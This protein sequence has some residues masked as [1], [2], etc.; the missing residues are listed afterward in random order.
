MQILSEE[1]LAEMTPDE[2]REYAKDVSKYVVELLE[3]ARDNIT[4]PAGAAGAAARALYTKLE[5][6]V[7]QTRFLLGVQPAAPFMPQ[8]MPAGS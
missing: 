5:Q 6:A 1:E 7:N 3:H 4:V 2:Q 8:F